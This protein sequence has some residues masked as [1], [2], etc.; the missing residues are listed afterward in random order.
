M[1]FSKQIIHKHSHFE[2]YIENQN[3]TVITHLTWSLLTLSCCRLEYIGEMKIVQRWYDEAEHTNSRRMSWFYILAAV[4]L[5]TYTH[6]THTHTHPSECAN[7]PTLWCWKYTNRTRRLAC[8]RRFALCQ[9]TAPRRA[10]RGQRP[11]NTSSSKYN[12]HTYICTYVLC[13]CRRQH[14]QP[15]HTWSKKNNQWNI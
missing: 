5:R 8:N 12:L 7:A 13:K 3:A 10:A 4:R 2:I 1:H 14:Y 15:K 9:F 11:Q 6:P